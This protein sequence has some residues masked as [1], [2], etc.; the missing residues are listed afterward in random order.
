MLRQAPRYL[1][2]GRSA[3]Q[4]MGTALRPKDQYR[5]IG[6]APSAD[7]AVLGQS[8]R[9][10]VAHVQRHLEASLYAVSFI[11]DVSPALELAADRLL[12]QP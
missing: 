7:R 4:A 9:Q 6:F 2:T 3:R 1:A 12:D 5:H 10:P 8:G 11:G